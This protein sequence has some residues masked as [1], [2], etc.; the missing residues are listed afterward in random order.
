M[1][2]TLGRSG[3]K[4]SDVGFGC[5]AI[6]GRATSGGQP[7]GWGAADDT[8]SIAAIRRALD[9]GI[10]FFDTADIYG[11]GHS[12]IVLG[13]AL[14]GHRDEVVIATKFGYTFDAKERVAQGED[15]SPDYIRRAC[16]ASLR[17]LGTDRI[18][19]YQ[20]HRGDLPIDEAG[21]VASILEEL[22][23]DGHIRA[24]GWSTDDPR[25]VRGFAAGPHCTAIQHG[26]N[27]LTETPEMF[28]ICEV[29]DLASVIRGPLAMGLLTGKYTAKTQLAADD[30]RSA[31]LGAPAFTG[32]RPT[33]GWLARLDAIR[34]VLAG[35]GRTLTQG[36]LCWL[37]ARS[38]RA[39]PIPGIRTVEQ[40]E[41]NAGAN[42]IGPLSPAE[43]AEIA[44]LLA[45]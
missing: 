43:M 13:E 10:T 27:V 24:Y 29:L 5:W 30:V 22:V 23:A 16:Q 33:P 11:A 4:V 20:L 37:L 9:L 2:R 8:A 31:Q 38:Q 39:V 3:V 19:L 15:C 40:A 26:A 7:I 14:T 35:D 44:G 1:T 12:E 21:E 18:D 28:N 34:E 17:R 25:R 41:E 42:R 32:G 6:G 45:G 36:A